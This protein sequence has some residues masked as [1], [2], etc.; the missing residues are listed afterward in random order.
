MRLKLIAGNLLIVLLVG[1]GSYLAVRTQL[2]A[3]LSRQL[4]EGIG[5]DSE[6]VAR[7]WRADGA[8]LADAVSNRAASSAVRN[9]FTASGETSRRGRAFEAAQQVSKWFQDP[10]R[11][12][13][14][15]AHI[16]AVIDETGRVIAR[17]TDPNR[18]FG[19]PLLN[20]VPVVRAVL[21]HG[22]AR[23][24]VWHQGDKLLQ[25][26]VAPVRNDQGGVVGALLVG[27]DLSNGFA[28]QEAALI[29]NEVLFIMADR[30]YSTSTSVEVRDA[31]Q[32]ALYSPP[33]D[34][35]TAAALQGK[36]TL[37]WT[38]K[39]AGD[40]YVGM[41][42]MLPMARGLEAGYVVL[43]HRGKHT[44]LA[45]VAN[46]ILWLSLLGLIGVAI[47]GF[48][49]ANQ[50]MD[51]IE[52]ME[53]DILAVINGRSDVRLEVETAELGGLSY[54]VN[55]LINLFTGVAEEDDEGRAVTSS[56]GWEAVSASGPDPAARLS[57]SGSIQRDNPDAAAL[58]AL[59]ERQ[60]YAQ[61]YREYIAAKQSMG[62]DVSN[63][64]EE[65]FI[66]R[67][68][69]N[70]AHLMKKH[71]A[72]MVRFEVETIGGQVNLKPVVIH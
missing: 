45:E 21:Q 46:M 37:P 17:D 58:A 71:G 68:K 32:A 25:V 22:A 8:R 38:A 29:G 49:I 4:E 59:P 43:G 42:A 23:Y 48:I 55:Q 13:R 35:G 20:K 64:P 30:I 69:G 67:I 28:Q 39:L 9:V 47:Y 31:L 19:E 33:L 34:S 11:G 63:I 3:E 15:R 24:G 12:R 14:E 36:P 18:M 1:L 72:Q 5:D 62:E 61:L 60:Y 53:D 7:S 70:A 57:A 66:E 40:A 52:Q 50:I 56:G 54:R 26:G 27:Y 6:I 65:R 16:V 10:A 44:A 2:R 51:P 41:T